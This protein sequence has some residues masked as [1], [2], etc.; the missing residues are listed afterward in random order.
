[1]HILDGWHCRHATQKHLSN[2]FAS[3][4]RRPP[5]CPRAAA[6]Y[7]VC[8]TDPDRNSYPAGQQRRL[9]AQNLRDVAAKQR[10]IALRNREMPPQIEQRQLPN[11][12]PR[13]LRAHQLVCRVRLA[14]ALVMGANPPDVHVRASIGQPLAQTPSAQKFY[15]TTFRR[16]DRVP[17]KTDTYASL[18]PS[19]SEKVSKIG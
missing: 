2:A 14:R 12:L 9:T 15:G 6:D 13:T 3:T 4:R 16:R 10:P 17:S 8:S 11:T 1:M 19:E 5:A 18:T 7:V